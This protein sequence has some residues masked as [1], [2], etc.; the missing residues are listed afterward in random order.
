[1]RRYGLFCFLG[2][3]HLD[4]GLAIGRA[5]QARG[6]EVTIFHIT[7][8]EAAV[9]AGGLPFVPLDRGARRDSQPVAHRRARLWQPT[10]DAIEAHAARTLREAPDALRT[11]QVD[12]IVVD[13]L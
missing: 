10:V 7:I 8:A 11:A 5:L 2:R 1:M 4:P 12:A 13:Q 9:R 3:G 6:H